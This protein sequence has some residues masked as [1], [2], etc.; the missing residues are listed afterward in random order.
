MICSVGAKLIGNAAS[1]LASQYK[2]SALYFLEFAT[3]SSST[4]AFYSGNAYSVTID[5][6]N[7]VSTRY[8]RV[9]VAPVSGGGTA[10]MVGELEIYGP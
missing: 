5:L 4:H 9:S 7:T 10:T 1:R 3:Q 2:S 8:V 6:P